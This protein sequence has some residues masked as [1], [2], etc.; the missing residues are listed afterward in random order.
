[1]EIYV[2]FAPFGM[3]LVQCQSGSYTVQPHSTAV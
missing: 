2:Q 3:K 1:M